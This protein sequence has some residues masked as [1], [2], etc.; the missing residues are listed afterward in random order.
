MTSTY[1]QDRYNEFRKTVRGKPGGADN[2]WHLSSYTCITADFLKSRNRVITLDN[3]HK[4]LVCARI[5]IQTG[6]LS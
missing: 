2:S 1:Q 4:L 5:N 3:W 6:D